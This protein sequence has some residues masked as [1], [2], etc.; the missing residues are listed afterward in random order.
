MLLLRDVSFLCV[1]QHL[2][3]TGR[4]YENRASRYGLQALLSAY[5]LE[6][7]MLAGEAQLEA[8]IEVA[9]RPDRMPIA[10]GDAPTSATERGLKSGARLSCSANSVSYILYKM[11]RQIP[12]YI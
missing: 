8:G 10:F 4:T 11:T 12:A 6:L 9:P 5:R 7:L 2:T 3:G 1:V